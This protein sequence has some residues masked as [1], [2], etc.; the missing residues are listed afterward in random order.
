ML[1]LAAAGTLVYSV[2][3]DGWSHSDA[4]DIALPVVFIVLLV[5][6]VIPVVRRHY[7]GGL[8]QSAPT[9]EGKQA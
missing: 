8:K 9:I 1:N 2:I 3:D 6:F 5:L 7:W 4:T